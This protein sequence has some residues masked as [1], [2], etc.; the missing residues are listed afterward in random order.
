MNP[1][2]HKAALLLREGGMQFSVQIIVRRQLQ[3]SKCRG[4]RREKE[5]IPDSTPV[6]RSFPH[7]EA[8]SETIPKQCQRGLR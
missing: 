6:S 8:Q 3:N 5:V 1:G 7:Q 4:A 2:V